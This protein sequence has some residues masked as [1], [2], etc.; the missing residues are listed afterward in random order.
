MCESVRGARG[1]S[2]AGTPNASVPAGG[3]A[4]NRGTTL[5]R[6]EELEDTPEDWEDCCFCTE[7]EQSEEER[8]ETERPAPL[9]PSLSRGAKLQRH[10]KQV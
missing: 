3:R 1:S 7:R 2:S 6:G 8:K 9:M 4:D 10:C 5:V